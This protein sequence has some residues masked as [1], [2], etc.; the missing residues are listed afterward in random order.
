VYSLQERKLVVIGVDARAE[1]QACVA[2]VHDL[3]V[4]KLDEIGL[5]FLVAGRDESVDL[6][7]L[8]ASV[9]KE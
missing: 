7:P 4:S 2:P 3:V 5:V 1:E 6:V 9:R 8:L